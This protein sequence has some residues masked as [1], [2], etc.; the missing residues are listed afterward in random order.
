MQNKLTKWLLDSIGDF[1]TQ[2]I[3]A[4]VLYLLSSVGI[5]WLKSVLKAPVPLWLVIVISLSILFGCVILFLIHSYKHTPKVKN[6]LIEAEVLKWE[7][8]FQNKSII[9]V[10]NIPFC[11][12]HDLRLTKFKDTYDCTEKDCNTSIEIHMLPIVYK[13]A[14][15]H[16]ERDIRNKKC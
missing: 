5:L 7:T 1:R 11:K 3:S 8:T 10:S 12:T 6:E 2:I 15:S 13:V 4:V 9:N 16:I 14:F